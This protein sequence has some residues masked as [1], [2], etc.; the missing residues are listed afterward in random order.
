VTPLSDRDEILGLLTR[1]C[2]L[3]DA[4]DWDALGGLFAHADLADERGTVFAS[5]AGDAARFYREAV[6]LHDGSPRTTHLVVHTAFDD[7]AGDGPVTA[8]SVY[9]VL[10]SLTAD[11]RPIV[12]GRYEDRFERDEAG[13]RFA[14]RRFAIDLAGDL[15]RHL[16]RTPRT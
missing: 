6:L 12:A 5:G 14:E 8:R 3:I 7:A 15:S 4:G 13:W 9:V 11:P 10:Q 2:D 16:R 1:Y